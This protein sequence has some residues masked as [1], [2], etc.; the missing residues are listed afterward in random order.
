MAHQKA[1]RRQRFYAGKRT[2][3]RETMKKGE[4]ERLEI[5]I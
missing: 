2:A 3:V 1:Q 5:S 4:G